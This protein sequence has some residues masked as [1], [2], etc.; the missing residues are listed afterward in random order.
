MHNGLPFSILVVDDDVDDLE[1]IDEAFKEIGFAAQVKKFLNGRALLH[2]LNSLDPTLYPS[3]I[4]L[5]NVLPEMDAHD[6]L[7]TLKEHTAYKDIP[8]VVYTTM[9]TPYKR[10]QLR[11]KG[12]SALLEKGSTM[13]EVIRL[14]QELKNLATSKAKT[15]Q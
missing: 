15:D 1:I 3:L 6:I 2:Y 9:L 10:E 7:I 8:V 11:A 5:D 13:P 4:V 12:V 14:A